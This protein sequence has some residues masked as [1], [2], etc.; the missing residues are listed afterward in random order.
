MHSDDEPTGGHKMGSKAARR[1]QEERLRKEAEATRFR[2][3][4]SEQSGPENNTYVDADNVPSEE[5]EIL[6]VGITAR[7]GKA[8]A[9]GPSFGSGGAGL[10]FSFAVETQF[11][12]HEYTPSSQMSMNLSESGHMVPASYATEA[13]ITAL[14]GQLA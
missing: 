14:E 13:K 9:P 3:P 4:S 10:P 8:A 11:N 5:E 7:K 12:L 2:A 1:I 6:P